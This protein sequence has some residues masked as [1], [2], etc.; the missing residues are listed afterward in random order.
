MDPIKNPF[1]PGAGTPPPELAGR[2]EILRAVHIA[3]ERIRIGNAAKSVILLG[4][5]GVGKTVLLDRM[6]LEARSRGMLA[7][8]LEAPEDRSLPALVAPELRSALLHLSAMAKARSLAQ[9]ALG[10]LVGFAKA[11][12]VTFKDVELAMDVQPIAGADNGDLERDLPVLFAKVG[13]A[14]QA[15]ETALILFA[16]E[17]QY[18]AERELAVL[19][20]ALHR[21]AQAKLPVS[22]VGAGLP[23]LRGSLGRAKS[24]AERLF[25]FPEVGALTPE[26][27]RTAL[28]KPIENAG[29][30]L[31]DEALEELLRATQCY[32]YF[33]QEWGKHVWDQA[34][35]GS[36]IQ[37]DDVA[38]GTVHALAALDAGFF[39]VRFDRLTPAEK[40]YL[41]GMAELGEGPHRSGEIATLLGRT[42]NALAPLRSKLTNKG[43][44]WSPS[45][46]DTAFTVPLFDAFMRRIM[47]EFS[48]Q[49]EY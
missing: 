22:L 3:L 24:Y 12:K 38:S 47:P 36:P 31:T 11:I 9:E 29:E 5:R 48:R 49:I 15:A 17:L 2:G 27:A 8:R 39:G 23:Q 18:V 41:R 7:V 14:A 33:L 44:I 16:D 21:C 45:H 28:R 19:I 37:R 4:L 20:T 35:P 43:M 1:A 26:A 32:P 10:L 46:G 30:S 13:E 6:A 34:V 25:D 42:V 40:N